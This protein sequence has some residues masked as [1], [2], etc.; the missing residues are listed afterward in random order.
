[1]APY[2]KPNRLRTPMMN[3]SMSRYR[4]EQRH[5]KVALGCVLGG[6]LLY[7]VYLLVVVGI[8]VGLF[9]LVWKYVFS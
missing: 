5:E 6:I 1:M 3:A 8:A 2:E 9:F 7:L 4:R